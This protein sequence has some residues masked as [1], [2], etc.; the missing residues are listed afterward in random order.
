MEVLN[1]IIHGDIRDVAKDLQNDSV[2]AIITSPP[3]LGLRKYGK[4]S[5]EIRK[6][7]G[8]EKNVELYVENLVEVF[9][10]LKPILKSD[11]TLWVN[12]GDSYIDSNLQGV[13]WRF[14]LKMQDKGW[15]LRSDIIWHK[16]NAMPSSVKNR[17]TTDHEYIFLFSKNKKYY[18]D[19]DAIR[20]EHI[21]FTDKSKMRGGR[22]H[23]GKINGT[24]EMGKNK[25]NS[26]LHRGR[27]DQAFNPLGRNKRTVWNIPVARFKGA[28]FAVFPEK[29]V[30][31]CLL[32]STK[33]NDTVLDPFFGSG[34]TGLVSLNHNRKFIG[35]ELI[36]EYA[37]LAKERIKDEK[38]QLKFF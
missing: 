14:A 28:H 6:E 25:G 31:T 10:K 21:T 18:Y 35:V 36:K 33:E 23:I 8:R 15:I 20:E 13:P 29:L 9:E 2:Q 22:N 4:E 7:I 16:P 5:N 3:Y 12:L 26:N 19:A 27:W 24:P 11:G 32:A 37:D 34:T 17:P 38:N 1:D 30:E